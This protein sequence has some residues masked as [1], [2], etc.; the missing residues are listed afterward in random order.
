MTYLCGSTAVWLLCLYLH[1]YNLKI[2]TGWYWTTLPN[3]PMSGDRET[4]QETKEE[5][6]RGK[7]KKRKQG[8]DREKREEERELPFKSA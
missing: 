8:K 2:Y 6:E 4:V 3:L 7:E 5:I 1:W